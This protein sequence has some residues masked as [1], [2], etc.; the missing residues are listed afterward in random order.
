MGAKSE[1]AAS[2]CSRCTLGLPN[3]GDKLSSGCLTAAFSAPRRKAE[4]LCDP[5]ILK[6]FKKRQQN[7]KW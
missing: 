5:Y 1:M 2:P 4:L 6:V 7:Q 3:K